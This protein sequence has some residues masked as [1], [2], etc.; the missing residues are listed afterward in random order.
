MT[1][2]NVALAEAVA[3]HR[4]GRLP[5]AEAAYLGV[6]SV[7]PDHAEA[8]RGLAGLA[9][10]VGRDDLAVHFLTRATAG[11]AGGRAHRDLGHALKSLG[12][13]DEALASYDAALSRDP[14][15]ADAHLGR[16]SIHQERGN[17]EEAAASLERASSLRP[18]LADAHFNLGVVSQA[19]GRLEQ[20]VG[21]YGRLVA[22]R[23]GF[24]LGHFALG[25]AL[26][27]L[28]RLA[29]AAESYQRAAVT[30]PL[31][32]EAHLN[33]ARTFTALAL[34][35]EARAALERGAEAASQ[36]PRIHHQLGDALAAEGRFE[37]AVAGYRRA[38]A[39]LPDLAEAHDGL[40]K[41]LLRL[42]RHDDA[43][44]SLGRAV[45][46]GIDR[47]A[48]WMGLGLALH[49]T[50]RLGEAVASLRRAALIEPDAPPILLALGNA[51]SDLG[52]F[53]DAAT[54]YRR[55]IA[56]KAGLAEAQ[57]KLGQVLSRQGR[58]EEALGHV[59][60]ATAL[61]SDAAWAFGALGEVLLTL[62]RVTEAAAA[63]R[64]ALEL[65]PNL[66]EA[67]S[68][69]IL[70]M[71]RDPA[72]GLDEQQ[73]E[74]RLWHDRHARPLEAR[75]RPHANAP[76]PERPLRVGYVSGDFRDH[77]AARVFGGVLRHH[78]RE[79]VLVHCYS[80]SRAEDATTAEFRALADGWRDTAD[81]G[82]GALAK[83]IHSDRIDILVDL[84]GHTTGNRLPVFARKPAPIQVTAWGHPPGTGLATID[85]VLSDPVYLPAGHRS[86][87]A[88]RVVDLPC[89]VTCMPPDPSCPVT[90]SPAGH[91]GYVTFACC[92]RTARIAPEVLDWWARILAAVP[93]SRLALGDPA[94]RDAV[95][96]HGIDPARIDLA[97]FSKADIGLDPHPSCGGLG[98]LDAAWMGIPVVTLAGPTPVSRGGAAANVAIGLPDFVA[99][100]GE[101]YVAIAIYEASHLGALARLRA[102]ARRRLMGLPAANPS[103]YTR[104]VEAAYRDLWRRWCSGALPTRPQG[105]I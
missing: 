16:G 13:L 41:C 5:E 94:Q 38:V 1:D 34:P 60:K 80:T 55:A 18:D 11:D 39:L 82:S 96:A 84:S 54:A 49:R 62:G 86:Q 46:L 73:A 91:N 24:A 71:D 98:V 57:G 83:A 52:Q 33:L 6:L 3:H 29:R 100:S 67:H 68:T 88:E 85:A 63:C 74:R 50:G 45:A 28:G 43:I 4:A 44:V 64:R 21:A 56:R 53:D 9:R 27:G 25:G 90:P 65:D 77:P 47:A 26:S 75:M 79:Q 101:D 76:D 20:A 48:T 103:L 104:A 95:A 15:L 99:D 66:I 61:A 97:D 35:Q 81:M 23:P 87:L 72:V 30:D 31:L 58:P 92:D 22:L 36:F 89:H 19:L 78:D 59:V 93:G 17:L 102:G 14:D 10:Q 8:L 32:E 37:A 42:E 51:L 70:A 12:R 40:G 2:A 7:A 105:G 69:L